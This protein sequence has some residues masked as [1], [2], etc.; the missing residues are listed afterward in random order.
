MTQLHQNRKRRH[1]YTFEQ[2]RDLHERLRYCRGGATARLPTTVN[3][4]GGDSTSS[5]QSAGLSSTSTKLL[6]R[7]SNPS[8]DESN[9]D[10]QLIVVIDSFEKNQHNR[11]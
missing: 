9:E 3:V 11:R 10:D 4:N 5:H 7:Y 2:Q 8:S 6:C 1:T